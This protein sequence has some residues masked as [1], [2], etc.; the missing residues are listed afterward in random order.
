[1]GTQK[2]TYEEKRIEENKNDWIE[3]SKNIERRKRRIKNQETDENKKYVNNDNTYEI[4]REDEVELEENKET[5][6]N[7]EKLVMREKERIACEYDKSKTEN[8]SKKCKNA[9]DTKKNEKH[10]DDEV[11]QKC[12]VEN[13]IWEEM[14]IKCREEIEEK[15]DELSEIEKEM[16]EFY[17]KQE[18]I[19]QTLQE[20]TNNNRDKEEKIKKMSNE[21]NDT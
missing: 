1:M 13:T 15:N 19:N 2:D 16:E 11:L 7:N 20:N 18:K 17:K 6:M 12:I 10:N 14:I 3:V 8:E 21:I 4:L 5:R 9:M